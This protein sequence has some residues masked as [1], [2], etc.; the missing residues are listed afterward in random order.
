MATLTAVPPQV[1]AIPASTPSP[2]IELVGPVSTQ[3]GFQY[4]YLVCM[5][6]T[7]VAVR[8]GIAA[9]FMFGLSNGAIPPV[10]GLIGGLLTYL[11]QGKS[12]KYRQQTEAS[13]LRMRKA[14][15]QTKPN[16]TYQLEQVKSISFKDV[17]NGGNLIL[18]DIILEMMNGSKQKYAIQKGDFDKARAVLEQRYPHLCR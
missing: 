13:L 14:T 2:A 3:G 12:K 16:V 8:Q 6:D 4:W 5:A 10:F 1:K 7:I 15:L 11:V 18:P 9:F 17:K